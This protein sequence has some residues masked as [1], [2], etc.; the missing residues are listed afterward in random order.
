MWRQGAFPKDSTPADVIEILLLD[1]GWLTLEGIH[2]QLPERSLAAV[3]RA[4]YRLRDDGQVVSRK[5][6]A[7]RGQ[8]AQNEWRLA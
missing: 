7:V 8:W 3:H 4:L 2:D 5:R 6:P 1:G